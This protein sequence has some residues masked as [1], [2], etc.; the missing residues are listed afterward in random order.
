ME[1]AIIVKKERNVID[2]KSQDMAG[3]DLERFRRTVLRGV[4]KNEFEELISF[5]SGSIPYNFASLQEFQRNR[6]AI[7]DDA[8]YF[9]YTITLQKGDRCSLYLD[10]DRPGK[11]VIEGR[12]KWVEERTKDL[13]GEFPKGGE[14]YVVHGAMGVFIIW[15]SVVIIA[16]IILLIT[17]LIIGLD[18]VMISSVIFTS[19]VLGIYL[20]IVKS[21]EIQPANT[22][23][24]V[25]RRN[26]WLET[27]LHVLTIALGITSA[28]LATI[29]VKS[30]M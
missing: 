23:S 16:S 17:T 10:P 2:L 20:S 3:N 7:P 11:L 21:K 30:V 8:S 26:Y 9:S 1:I 28:I 18:S 24:F 12:S 14:R 6:K 29:I 15:A 19:S 13:E 25:K 22:I 5:N 4:G 27:F